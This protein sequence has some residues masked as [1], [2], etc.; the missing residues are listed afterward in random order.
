M[1]HLE[2]SSTTAL[3]HSSEKEDKGQLDCPTPRCNMHLTNSFFIKHKGIAYHVT[4][5]F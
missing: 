5:F 3:D 1:L 2:P 4:V